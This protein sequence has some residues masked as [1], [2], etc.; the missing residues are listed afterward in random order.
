MAFTVEDGTGVKDANA[1]ITLA[2]ANEYHL[3]RNHTDWSS[4]LAKLQSAIVRATMYVDARFGR[5]FRGFRRSKTQELEWPRFSALDNDGYLLDGIPKQLQR[6]VAEYALRTLQFG[7][8]A[9][10]V[11]PIVPRQSHSDGLGTLESSSSVQTGVV[12]KVVTQVG[13]ILSSTTYRAP[14]KTVTSASRVSRTA[15]TTLVDGANIPQ[16][17]AA[18]IWLEELITNRSSKS[19]RRG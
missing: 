13:P 11:P 5:S 9:P 2:F 4:S 8:L 3:D 17:P 16:Y 12:E 14:E 10:D 19:L 6:A 18:D 15:H 1:Y 7:E